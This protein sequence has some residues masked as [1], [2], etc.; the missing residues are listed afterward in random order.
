[1]NA[2]GELIGINTAIQSPT[3][4]YSG[5]SFAVPINIARKVVGDLKE[6]GKVQRAVIGIRMGE[7]TPEAA[8]ELNVKAT[9]GIYVGEVIREEQRKRPGSRQ[10]MSYSRLTVMK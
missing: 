10:A 4:S 2:Q 1:M 9:S 8:K 5:Y 3:G 7:L 6:Y